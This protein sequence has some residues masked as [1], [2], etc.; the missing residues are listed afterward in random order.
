MLGV[1]TYLIGLY[2]QSLPERGSS[3]ST[4]SLVLVIS[5]ISSCLVITLV[6]ANVLLQCDILA[7]LIRKTLLALM[8]EKVLK[9]PISGVA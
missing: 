6:R 9:L 2:L 8:Y 5:I 7:L 3:R 4:Y 1:C